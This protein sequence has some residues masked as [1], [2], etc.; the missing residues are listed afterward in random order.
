M[1]AGL[2]LM[3]NPLGLVLLI[4]GLAVA[5]ATVNVAAGDTLGDG[6]GLTAVMLN[7]PAEVASAISST[8]VS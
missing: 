5:V 3:T 4:T 7:L 2:E 6:T 1:L 8:N